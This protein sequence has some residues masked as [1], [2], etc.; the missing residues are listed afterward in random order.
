MPCT[1]GWSKRLDMTRIVEAKPLPREK[2]K[3][4]LT[5]EGRKR[6]SAVHGENGVFRLS[7]EGF[8]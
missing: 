7:I 5:E 6:L 8:G 1:H 3:I 4:E 2:M